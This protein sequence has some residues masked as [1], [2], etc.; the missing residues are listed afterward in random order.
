ML[1]IGI[2]TLYNSKNFGAFL[3]AFALKTFLEENYDCQTYFIE[4][5]TEESK[6]N[7]KNLKKLKKNIYYF[8]QNY[9]FKKTYQ[10]FKTIS[11]ED[12]LYKEIDTFILGSDEIW[13]VQNDF[14]EHIPEFFGIKNRYNISYACS[15]NKSTVDDIKQ[16]YGVQAF[17][18]IN[19]ISVR[20][21][22]TLKV[23]K[24][25][26][27]KGIK[28]VDPTFL[29]DF[30]KY[31]KP[32]KKQNFILIYGYHFN[33]EQIK[34]IKEFAKNKKMSLCAIGQY[35]NWC[36]HNI[37]ADAFDFLSYIQACNYFITSTFHGSVFASI[38]HK[39]FGVYVGGNV[40]VK[41][42]IKEMKLDEFILDNQNSIDKILEKECN[43]SVDVTSSKKF[44]L[45]N[46]KE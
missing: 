7:F 42:F 21:N 3:Q 8:I 14:F 39:K 43:S 37:C 33:N 22:A 6:I 19:K 40:K 10:H 41:E 1:K 17:D 31:L 9:K 28:V 44:L 13:N 35:Q 26:N 32:V 30:S 24:S 12:K 5:N 20:D 16:M 25:C 38:F 23:V 2:Y 36:D 15:C 29:I 27:Q 45:E 11:K 46:L 34:T 18:K 4:N